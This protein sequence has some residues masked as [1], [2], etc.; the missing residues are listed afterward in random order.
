MRRLAVVFATC[1]SLFPVACAESPPAT[2]PT[3][4]PVTFATEPLTIVTMSGAHAFTVEVAATPEQRERGLMYRTEMAP[5]A[6]MIF[7]YHHDVEI[8]M[9][10]KNTVLPL[11]MVFMSADGTVFDVVKGAVPY[12][13][14]IIASEGKVR[15]VLEVNAGTVDRLQ[16][17]R[18]DKVQNAIFGNAP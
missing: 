13:L 17:R 10:M 3:P 4:P 11:D 6:G 2:E 5:D 1:L 12:S 14:D 18:G 15:A 9:W 8:S 7:D 16:I